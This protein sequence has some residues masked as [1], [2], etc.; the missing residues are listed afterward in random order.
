MLTDFFQPRIQSLPTDVGVAVE[1][2]S[3][4]PQL[5]AGPFDDF[6]QGGVLRVQIRPVDDALVVENADALPTGVEFAQVAFGARGV[7]KSMG[8]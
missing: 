2:H 1:C 4:L 6:Q 3:H 5:R 7:R 8:G